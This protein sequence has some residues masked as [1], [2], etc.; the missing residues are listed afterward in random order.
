MSDAE[1][2]MR[3]E[4]AHSVPKLFKFVHVV[5]SLQIMTGPDTHLRRL[6]CLN[7]KT[8]SH[9]QSHSLQVVY[10]RKTTRQTWLECHMASASEAVRKKVM[11]LQGAHLRGRF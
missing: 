9:A 7:I 5:T 6:D 4:S 3:F 2:P 8:L 1:L 11:Q 10:K